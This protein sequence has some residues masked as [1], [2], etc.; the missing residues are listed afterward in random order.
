M[1]KKDK[2]AFVNQLLIY[3]LV[4]IGFSGSIG[5]GTVWMRQQIS[6]TANATKV[7][8][9]R[10][11]EVE[12]RIA[13]VSTS[14]QSEQDPRVLMRRNVEWKLG[15]EMPRATQVTRIDENPM[16]KLATKRNSRLFVDG[17]APAF[18]ITSRR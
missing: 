13:E 10:I 6:R 1:N 15:L 4:M 3:T 7:L 2:H 16:M 9:S 11:I 18:T 14:I 17:V 12:R 5:M 8:N